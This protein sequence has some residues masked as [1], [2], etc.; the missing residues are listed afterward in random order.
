MALQDRGAEFRDVID[1]REDFAD[2]RGQTVLR[3]GSAASNEE[4]RL[5]ERAA[6][7]EDFARSGAADR[8]FGEQALH[9]EDAGELLAEFGAQDG[10]A[11]EIGHGIEARFDFG[12]I[13]RGTQQPL[14]QQPAAHAGGGLVEDADQGG[15]FA[16]ED[17]LE[18]FEIA[19]GDGVEHHGFGAVVERR[20]VEVIE[21]G[22]LGVAQVVEN[23]AGGRDR[24][25]FTGEAAAIER[26]QSEVLAEGAV[27]VVEGEDPVFDLSGDDAAAGFGAWEAAGVRQR[28]GLRARR[29]IRGRR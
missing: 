15:A 13:E 19:D 9:I 6:E 20:A 29:A 27:G 1:A 3:L 7:G 18:Q 8:D 23:G 10:F 22:A 5:F 14:A 2:A 16:R 12:A 11:L 21:R 24:G 4:R 25:A 17:G 26:E 28:R